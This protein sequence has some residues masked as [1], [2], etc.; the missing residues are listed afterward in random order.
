MVLTRTEIE[1]GLAEMASHMDVATIMDKNVDT[2]CQMLSI[3]VHPSFKKKSFLSIVNPPPPHL[4][5]IR[6]VDTVT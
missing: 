2:L 3:S 4:S 1:N 6:S 5:P